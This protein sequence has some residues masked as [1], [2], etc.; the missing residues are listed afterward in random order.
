ME[1][2]ALTIIGAG[3]VGLGIAASVKP[4]GPAFMLEKERKYGMGISSRN[5]EVVHAGIYYPRDSLKAILCV[6]G[7]R[8]IF[9][10][11]EREG[12][13]HAWVGKVIVATS[14]GEMEKLEDLY[15][16]G[17]LNGVDGLHMLVKRERER[18]EP[19]VSALGALSSMNT[20]IVSAHGLM[21]CLHSKAVAN[22]Y[23]IAQGNEVIGIEQT[24]DGYKITAKTGSETYSFLSSVV[25]NSAGLGSERI[26][27]MIGLGDERLTLHFCK[28]EYFSIAPG[29]A[30]MVNGLVYPVPGAIGL[31]AHF[32]KGLEGR[33]RLGP[34]A[35]FIEKEEPVDYSVDEGHARE[36]FEGARKFL[37]FLEQGDLAPDMS[38]VRPKLSGKEGGFR[39]FVIEE[40]LPGYFNLTGIDSPGLTCAISIGEYLKP[41]VEGR[42]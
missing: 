36:F 35:F 28:G 33:G 41:M 19:N 18:R 10:I 29:K 16:N 9:E 38:G 42:L 21:D 31:G 6:K 8:L 40:S 34:N 22:G 39:D 23:E 24:G 11:C 15:I 17:L 25:I 2:V 37:P 30:G 14:E 27:R 26:N 13:P 5:S 32:T 20:G 1:K 12:V 7:N 4:K 3:A